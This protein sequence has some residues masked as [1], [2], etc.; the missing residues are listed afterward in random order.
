MR[1]NMDR[2]VG[3]VIGCLIGA[4]CTGILAKYRCDRLYAEARLLGSISAIG[5]TAP[6]LQTLAQGRLDTA[7]KVLEMRLVSSLREAD[8]LTARGIALEGP[9]PNF[10]DAARRAH[11]YAS[12]SAL[13][14]DVAQQADR[15]RQ[16]LQASQDRWAA[17]HPEVP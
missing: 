5:T 17:R 6:A 7:R 16:R 13:S 1:A 4:V 10:I 8:Q 2:I 15:V 3:V 9:I 11:E 14:P 12:R